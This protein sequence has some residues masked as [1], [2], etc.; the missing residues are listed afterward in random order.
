MND[1]YNTIF[2]NEYHAHFDAGQNPCPE[3]RN[4]MNDILNTISMAGIAASL[5]YAL[6][7]PAPQCAHAPIEQ[8]QN[9]VGMLPGGKADRLLM[10]N[11]DAVAMW[12]F[13][14]Y[15]EKFAPVA[16]HTQLTLP[17]RTV[18]PSVTPVCFATMYTGALPEVHGIRRYEKP[19][20]KTDTLFDAAI[21]AGKKVAIVSDPQCSIGNI[22]L[23]RDMDYYRFDTIAEINAKALEL[24]AED[25]YDILVVYNGNYDSAMHKTGTESVEA[26]A[27]LDDNVHSFDMLAQAVK[28]HWTTHNTLMGF[29]TDH[30]CHDID[31]NCGS[32]GLDMP[33]DLN[34]AHFYG[35]VPRKA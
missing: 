4:T 1:V 21:R 3:R 16:R 20:L 9:L 30:G 26:L 6:D 14:K 13:Q 27:Q 35:I 7:I 10:Y 18:M 17:L 31:G 28:E 2:I 5:A 11:P 8:M 23:E 12:L 33:E 29:A 19:V 32:H 25:K 22:F 15:T 24:I 34:V